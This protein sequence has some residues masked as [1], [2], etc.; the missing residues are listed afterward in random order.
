MLPKTSIIN[1]HPSSKVE[2][3]HEKHEKN[4]KTHE[5]DDG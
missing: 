2:Q 1:H 5:H 3:K 4:M